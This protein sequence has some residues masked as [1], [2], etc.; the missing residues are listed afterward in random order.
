ML[1]WSLRWRLLNIDTWC[2]VMT[3]A[4]HLV[5]FDSFRFTGFWEIIVYGW[6]P[7][8]PPPPPPAPPAHPH[9]HTSLSC[10]PYGSLGAPLTTLQ[11][12]L[13]IFSRIFSPLRV[14]EL[15]TCPL[16]DVAFPPILL[17]ISSYSPSDS[18]ICLFKSGGHKAC[19]LEFSLD[20]CCRGSNSFC[21]DRKLHSLYV[22][23]VSPSTALLFT[24]RGHGGGCGNVRLYL[25]I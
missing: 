21:V 10:N 5:K 4:V 25:Y 3:E 7:P 18:L 6:Y 15:Q 2:I 12:A 1:V 17:S 20:A 11:P 24:V 9:A 19:A 16:F 13:S 23:I 14:G 22:I 8:P